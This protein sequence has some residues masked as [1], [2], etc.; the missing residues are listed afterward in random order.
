MPGPHHAVITLL[1]QVLLVRQTS[2][3]SWT[4]VPRRRCVTIPW[5]NISLQTT[6]QTRRRQAISA[7]FFK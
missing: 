1:T 7:N 2:R 3:T 5:M 4:L 6:A